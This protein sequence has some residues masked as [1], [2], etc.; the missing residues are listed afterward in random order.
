MRVLPEVVVMS[1]PGLDL[2][3]TPD[4]GPDLLQ[5]LH[6]T[7][8]GPAQGQGTLDHTPEVGQDLVLT[9]MEGVQDQEKEDIGLTLDHVLAHQALTKEGTF[10]HF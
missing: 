3:H 10:A 8:P 7:H 9:A 2:Y 1:V 4:L 5:A 6:D